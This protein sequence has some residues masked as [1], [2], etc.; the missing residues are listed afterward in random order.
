MGV[1]K[2]N[3]IQ[4]HGNPIIPILQ[5]I[6]RLPLQAIAVT[7]NDYYLLLGYEVFRITIVIGAEQ[8]SFQAHRKVITLLN[9][10]KTCC[11]DINAKKSNDIH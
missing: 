9:R 8:K 6:D 2:S 4:K 5:R 10:L 3:H 7:L 11:Q 1:L